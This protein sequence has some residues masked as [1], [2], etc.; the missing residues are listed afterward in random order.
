LIIES[1]LRYKFELK[2]FAVYFSL[3]K[4]MFGGE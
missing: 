2:H 4:Y 1:S 3:N